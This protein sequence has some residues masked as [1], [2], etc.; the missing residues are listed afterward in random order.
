MSLS[1]RFL[2]FLFLFVFGAGAFAQKE[3]IQISGIVMTNDSLPRYIPFAHVYVPGAS[4]GTMTS[5]E[6]FFSFA[7]LPG[8]TIRVS[9][10]GYQTEDLVLADSLSSKAYLARVVMRPDTFLLQEVELY[11][12]PSRDRFKE[13]FLS[14]RIPTTQEDI[15]MRN[16]AIQELKARAEKMGYSPEEIQ[17][18][19]IQVQE[20]NIY[21]Y[22]RYQGFDNGGTAILGALANPFAWQRFFESLKK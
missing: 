17:S 3:P 12:W 7:T 11:P 14:T 21:N 4:R 10:I 13:A 19:A 6:G 16:L 1:Q 2:F 8:D 5:G 18:Y 9:C 22:G 20:R 15:A